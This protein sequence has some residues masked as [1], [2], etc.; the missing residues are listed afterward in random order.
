MRPLLGKL[1]VEGGRAFDIGVPFDDQPEIAVIAEEIGDLAQQR[2]SL[3][4]AALR[5]EG[6]VLPADGLGFL[7]RF[8]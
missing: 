6:D 7:F 3:D 2:K 5:L 8:A 1:V 4:L